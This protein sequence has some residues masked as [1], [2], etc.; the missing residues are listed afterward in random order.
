MD[1]ES[2]KKTLP[3]SSRAP[4]VISPDNAIEY[5]QK[6]DMV[7]IEEKLQ[8]KDPLISVKWSRPEVQQAIKYYRNF[9]VLNVK[10][11]NKEIIIPPSLEI[12]EIWHHHILD[13]R[14]YIVDCENIFGYYFHHYPYFGT[15]GTND[16][17][18][19]DFTFNT[20]QNLHLKEFGEYIYE[21]KT[22]FYE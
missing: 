9:L 20:T 19:L 12:D 8:K 18:A 7:N 21:I 3:H 6:M 5:I 22:E 11:G 17:K 13:T 16:K 15:R 1:I 10:Y 2:I 4:D 14:R